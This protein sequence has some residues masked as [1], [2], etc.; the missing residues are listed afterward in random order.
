[1]AFDPVRQ[2][3]LNLWRAG[4]VLN[5]QTFDTTRLEGKD[6]EEVD[7]L[8]ERGRRWVGNLGERIQTRTGCTIDSRRALDFGCGVGRIALP[9]AERCEHVY[10]LDVSPAVLRE[11]DRMAKHLNL[12]NVEWL[13]ASAVDQLAGSYDLL[14]SFY[15]F[16]HIPSREGER[17]FAKLV[18]G[19]RPGGVAAVHFTI[20]PSKP[21]LDK[22]YPYMLVNSYS[23]NRLMRLL[24]ENGIYGVHV[25]WGNRSGPGSYEEATLVFRKD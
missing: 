15:V 20:R 8:Y 22:S 14:L 1:M 7:R 19:L 25:T 17:I 2:L 10:G 3:Q 16:Q 13:D 4:H 9:L 21:R 18:Q 24:A 23:L 11:A 5:E 12:T 6:D